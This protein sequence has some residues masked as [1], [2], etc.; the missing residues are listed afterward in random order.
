MKKLFRLKEWLTLDEAA[1]HL[2]IVFEDSVSS[3]DVLRLGLDNYLRLS[4]YFVNHAEARCGKIVHYSISELANAIATGNLPQDLNWHVWPAG[5]M[6]VLQPN[7]TAEE[8]EK[9]RIMLMSK[10]LGDD[11]YLT[12]DDDVKTITGVWDLPMYGNEKFDVEQM[13]Q[14][15]TRGPNVTLQGLD[16]T[17]VAGHGHIYQ[18][19][20]SYK[21]AEKDEELGL[22]LV[23]Y[24]PASGLPKDAVI[25]VRPEALREFEQNVVNEGRSEPEASQE[26]R[27]AYVSDKLAKMNQAAEK[28]W[29]NAKREDRGTHPTNAAVAAWLVKHDFSSTLAD[30]AATLIRPEW[31]PV[32]R[33]PEE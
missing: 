19:Q 20:D 26:H 32:G 27:R 12:L 9:D 31:A 8:S 11:Y 25:V 13:Y 23:R 5:A 1:Q 17:F 18:L 16:G 24:F 22:G 14:V 30:K 15:A 29:A 10:R 3:S 7:K 28:F 33:K 21:A 2:S 6:A 4:V